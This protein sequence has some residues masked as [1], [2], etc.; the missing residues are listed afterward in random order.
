VCGAANFP[1]PTP[2]CPDVETEE[3]LAHS[4]ATRTRLRLPMATSSQSHGDLENM[5]LASTFEYEERDMTDERLPS[6]GEALTTANPPESSHP[7]ST[8]GDVD[9][10][11]V[12]R[13]PPHEQ[14]TLEPQTAQPAS[15]Y[16]PSV[17]AFVT[18]SLWKGLA[19]FTFIGLA[20]TIGGVVRCVDSK[21]Y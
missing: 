10:L 2:K 14:L 21:N 5:P 9:E 17:D 16:R 4:L 13:P 7:S 1:S 19:L 18:G 6:Y 20:V 3:I 12:W 11:G 15:R 8:T